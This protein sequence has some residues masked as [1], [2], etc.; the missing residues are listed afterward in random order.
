[1]RERNQ[2]RTEVITYQVVQIIG[3]LTFYFNGQSGN[4]Q[5]GQ[6]PWPAQKRTHDEVN[7]GGEEMLADESDGD[8]KAAT[9]A[10]LKQHILF[11]VIS[12]DP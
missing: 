11:K 10:T 2:P 9:L 4:Q 5:H 8:A 3:N 7:G 1:M 6:P 12:G